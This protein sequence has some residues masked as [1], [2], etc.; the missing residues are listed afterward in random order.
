MTDDRPREEQALAPTVPSPS[1]GLSQLDHRH[2]VALTGDAALGVRDALGRTTRGGLGLARSA[3]AG[4]V[5]ELVP[6]DHLARGLRDGTL[7]AAMPA[8][9]DASIFIKNVKDGR[10]SAGSFELRKVKPQLLGPAGWQALALATQQHYLVEITTKLNDIQSG[11][12]EVLDRLNDDRIGTLRHIAEVVE[13]AQTIARRD[14]ALSA[15]RISEVRT[16]ARDAK[17]LWH[18][19]A[20]TARRHVGEYAAGK[21]TAEQAEETFAMLAQAT[22]VLA[23]CSDALAAL[24]YRTEAELRGQWPKSKTGCF[25]RCLSSSNSARASRTQATRGS[26]ATRSTAS[27]SQRVAPPGGCICRRSRSSARGARSASSATSSLSSAHR[28]RAERASSPISSNRLA[29]KSQ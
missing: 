12:D 28:R 29:T 19:I 7:R 18:Q 13:D 15:P 8:R 20:T 9:G 25:P 23:Q 26:G 14:G 16:A 2:A 11:V 3:R 10:G 17:E 4:D 24:P 21:K 1:T 6:P 22:R 5:F 27:V